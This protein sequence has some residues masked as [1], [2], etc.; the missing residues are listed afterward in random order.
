MYKQIFIIIL[1]L[2]CGKVLIAQEK[3]FGI[4]V[5][6]FYPTGLSLKYNWK[7]DVFIDSVI[8]VSAFGGYFHLG[9][10]NEFY[11][12][13]P[14]FNLYV[15]GSVLLEERKRKNKI[16]RNIFVKRKSFYGGIKVPF[17]VVYYDNQKNF[18]LFGEIGVNVL[19]QNNLNYYLS[20]ALGFHFYI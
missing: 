15:G 7:K 8:G 11:Q 9:F 10:L 2:F 1:F 19:F 12:L 14:N 16:W 17:G 4:G 3:K 20:F 6:L 18:D 5:S 13:N